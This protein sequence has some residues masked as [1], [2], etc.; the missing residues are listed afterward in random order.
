MTKPCYDGS[1]DPVQYAR[2]VCAAMEQT[3]FA[4]LKRIGDEIVRTKSTGA[5]VFTAGN[6]GSAATASHIVN[7]LIKGCRIHGRTGFRASCLNDANAVVTCLANDFSYEQAYEIQLRTLARRGDL[8]IVFSGSGN[9]GNI[10]RACETAGQMGM[11]VIGLGGRDGGNMKALCNLC[12]LAPTRNMEQIEDLHMFYVHAL[13][14]YMRDQLRRVWD[15]EII[16]FPGAEGFR[17]AVFGEG[18]QDVPGY[19]HWL[20]TLA[21]LGITQA[22]PGNL[23]RIFSGMSRPSLA[24][25]AAFC[26]TEQEVISAVA[27]GAYAVGVALSQ[28]PD[29]CVDEAKRC[30][31]LAAGACCVIPDFSSPERLRLL[32]GK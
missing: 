25:T 28:N 32:F 1:P 19:A 9:S 7:D 23:I 6:G 24:V 15:A 12:L 8:L 14:T 27:A 11:T 5:T 22:D 20:E 26:L 30:A 29:T 4:L 3:D 13:V 31:F 10:L 18:A 17:H 21:G 16:R 2:E